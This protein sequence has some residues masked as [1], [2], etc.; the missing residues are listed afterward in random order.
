MR[1]AIF[2]AGKDTI[3]AINIPADEVVDLVQMVQPGQ[4][5]RIARLSKGTT[6]V[7]V[8]AGVFKLFSKQGVRVTSDAT[9]VEIVET[10]NNKG[11]WPD[12]RLAETA[13]AT[14]NDPT[15]VAK[16]F[17]DAKSTSSD[18]LIASAKSAVDVK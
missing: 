7:V 4:E 3:L 16:F 9:G 14:G 8:Q 18:Q 13:K 10:P 12:A 17:V 15:A 6:N 2:T 5:V 1:T 11:D